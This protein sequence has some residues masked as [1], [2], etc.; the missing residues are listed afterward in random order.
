MQQSLSWR[1]TKPLRLVKK[2][3]NVFRTGKFQILVKKVFVVWKTD[4]L[5][6]VIKKVKRKL[7]TI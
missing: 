2:I 3:F 1:I 4:G 7:K 6:T 5:H